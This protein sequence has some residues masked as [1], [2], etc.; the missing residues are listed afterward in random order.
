[1][2][3]VICVICAIICLLATALA[4]FVLPSKVNVQS[5]LHLN[6]DTAAVVPSEN[7]ENAQETLPTVAPKAQENA[8]VV[9]PIAEVVPEKPALLSEITED[10]GEDGEKKNVEGIRYIVHW[11][12][13]LWDISNT[14]YRNPWLYPRIAKYN[15]I[16]DPDFIVSGTPIIIPK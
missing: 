9:S 4:L 15:N 11:G 13:T 1:M 3:A 6:Q 5:L 8:I 10:V 12:D 14:Y 7:T 2:A 16:T